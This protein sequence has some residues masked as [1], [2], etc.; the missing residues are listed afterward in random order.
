ML[1]HRVPLAHL[2]RHLFR[3]ALLGVL[4]HREHQPS[5]A[6]LLAEFRHDGNIGDVCLFKEQPHTTISDD[7][8]I[9]L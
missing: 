3:A 6:P 9:H 1:G 4:H 2:E 8:T 7:L 5:A